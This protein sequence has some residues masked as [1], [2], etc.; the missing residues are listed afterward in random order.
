M[1][2]LR[3]RNALIADGTG[4]PA[5]VGDI[6]VQATAASSRSARPEPS[7]IRPPRRSTPTVSSPPWLRRPAHA[8]RRAAV[9]GSA[10]DPIQRAR[11]DERDRR[12]LQPQPGAVDA[13]RTPTTTA[14]CWPR[15][16]ACR[17]SRSRQV[18]RGPG[19][20]SASTSTRSTARLG[21]NAGFLQGHSALRRH[22]MGRAANQRPATEAELDELRAEL[23]RSLAGGCARVVA[24]RLATCTATAT[25]ERVPARAAP[26]A[27][28]CSCSAGVVGQ[29]EGTTL[30][31]IFAGGDH[32][33][34]EAEADL[35]A[36]LSVGREPTAELEPPGRRRPRSRPALAAAERV[37]AGTRDRRPGRRAHHAD[38]RPD[39]HELPELLRAEPHAG[40][41]AR[42]STCRCPSAWRGCVIRK[43]SAGWWPAP[44]AR[45]PA[46]SAGSPISAATSSATRTATRTRACAGRLVRDIAAERGAGSVRTLIDIVCD[47]DLRTVLWPSAPDDD[48]AHWALRAEIWHDPDVMLGGSD[49]GRPPRPDVRRGLS[50]AVSRRLPARSPDPGA[51]GSSCRD[52]RRACAPVR[53]GRTRPAR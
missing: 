1:L 2:D 31:G 3:I 8:L 17:S 20:A 11:R 12:Q 45:R 27:K 36:R 6:G 5:Y 37:A 9:L 18:S 15:S 53:S 46:C 33:F 7:T 38:D 51:R 34:D 47:D 29:H 13:G 50:D 52:E 44:T 21:V 39:E 35:L 43:P 41:G 23:A 48:D 49:A 26:I 40:M 24:R 42:C 4:A 14:G 30:E 16:R 19:R 32:G 22:V 25:V 28:S 10:G